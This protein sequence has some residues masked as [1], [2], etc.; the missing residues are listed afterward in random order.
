MKCPTCRTNMV[1][2]SGKF[3][4]FYFCPNQYS[5]CNQKTLS[6]KPQVGSHIYRNTYWEI[7]SKGSRW[8]GTSCACGKNEF[9]IGGGGYCEY[10][11]HTAT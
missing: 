11:G 5:G 4:Q 7:R 10:C 3:G 1:K 9:R 6:C 2:R 8:E